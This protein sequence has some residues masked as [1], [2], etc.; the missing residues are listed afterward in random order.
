MDEK[1]RDTGQEKTTIQTE[2]CNAGFSV[3][4]GPISGLRKTNQVKFPPKV[5]FFFFFSSFS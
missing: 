4:S 1:E 3:W 5:F 2:V